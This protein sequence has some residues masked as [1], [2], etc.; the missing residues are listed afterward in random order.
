[1]IISPVKLD[2][3][4]ANVAFAERLDALVLGILGAVLVMHKGTTCLGKRLR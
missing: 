3:M 4:F 2:G 1:L